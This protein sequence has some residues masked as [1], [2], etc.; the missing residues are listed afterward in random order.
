VL[1]LMSYGGVGGPEHSTDPDS[2]MPSTVE[3]S[4]DDA[5]AVTLRKT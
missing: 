5:A 2:R 1:Y 4:T 3:F